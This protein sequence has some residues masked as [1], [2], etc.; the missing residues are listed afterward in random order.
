MVE[1]ES[2]FGA[3]VCHRRPAGLHC[4][5][6][7][8]LVTVNTDHTHVTVRRSWARSGLVVHPDEPWLACSPDGIICSS[9]SHDEG[10]LEVKCPFRCL[11]MS[12]DEAARSSSFCL[13]HDNQS[14]TLRQSHAYYYQ[15]Q[16]SLLVA[17]LRWA[18]FVV[19]SPQELFIERIPVNDTLHN[20]ML[21]KLRIFY[22][23]N[24]LPALFA[25]AQLQSSSDGTCSRRGPVSAPLQVDVRMFGDDHEVRCN[26]FE[27]QFSQSTI[28]GRNGSSACTVIACYTALSLLSGALSQADFSG[29][30]TRDIHDAFVQFIRAGNAAF[31]EA[32]LG[33]ELLAVYDALHLISATGLT[34]AP[35]GDIGCRNEES[36]VKEMTCLSEMAF[37]R[38]AVVPAVLV[39][40]PQMVCLAFTPEGSV[41]IFDSHL[42]GDDGALVATSSRSHMKTVGSFLTSLLLCISDGH[43]CRLIVG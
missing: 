8:C 39:Q 40:N 21:D 19:W 27:R 3:Y 6:I 15:V 32:D 35:R 2:S 24:L 33:A 26:F 41:V 42:H 30:L 38:A 7:S 13:K 16:H 11:S 9:S 4:D 17:G 10:L 20:R 22:R 23:Q 31:D 34:I 37:T 18:D 14:F 29:A 5:K 43:L 36:L 25:E 1:S 12:L 28:D